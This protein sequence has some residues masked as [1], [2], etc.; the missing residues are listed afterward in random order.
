MRIGIVC[1][2]TLGGSGIV[3]TELGIA[4]AERGHEVHLISY[5]KPVKFNDSKSGLHYHEVEISTY[6]LFDYSPYE[7]VLASKLVEVVKTENLDLLHV[8]YAIPHASAAFLAK[9]I[10]EAEGIKIPYITTLHGTDIT[11]VGRDNAF[12][13]VITFCINAS[14]VVTADSDS[15]KKDTLATFDITNEIEVVHN[16][17]CPSNYGTGN[18]GEINRSDYANDDERIITHISNFR[19]VKRIPDVIK[20]FTGIA[21]EIPAKLILVGDGPEME[22]IKKL[23]DES[24]FADRIVFTGVVKDPERIHSI[25]DLFVLPSESESF[26]LAALEAMISR[27]PVIGTNLGGMP[28]VVGSGKSGFLCELGDIDDMIAKALEILKSDDTLNVF[29]DEA[30]EKALTF[31]IINILPKY[32]ALYEKALAGRK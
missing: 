28:E 25:S 7:V 9:T 4:L 23:A 24:E 17:I 10:L 12:R 3:A 15:L 1:Y 22:S 26:G 2:P 18:V 16:F 11:L 32:E 21:K 31:D 29:K 5:K 30:H 8:H 19:K 13:S 6:P 27:V 14:D 20:V